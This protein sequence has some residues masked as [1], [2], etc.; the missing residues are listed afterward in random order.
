MKCSA[1]SSP[2]KAPIPLIYLW[3]DGPQT[4]VCVFQF[5][6]VAGIDR[7]HAEESFTARIPGRSNG[8]IWNAWRSYPGFCI[9]CKFFMFV[10]L[11][12]LQLHRVMRGYWLCWCSSYSGH[13][14]QV[15]SWCPWQFWTWNW[16][17]PRPR[18]ALTQWKRPLSCLS[19]QVLDFNTATGRGILTLV[20]QCTMVYMVLYIPVT[21]QKRDWTTQLGK[22]IL[23]TAWLGTIAYLVDQLS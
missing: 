12:Q 21:N 10:Q 7:Q 2:C 5:H 8:S 20:D 1:L 14:K 17:S 22:S 19:I 18:T 9:S 11:A 4:S 13:S 23:E 3:K 15:W 6:Q 16:A